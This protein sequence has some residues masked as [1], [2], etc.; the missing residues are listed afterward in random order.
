MTRIGI[1]GDVHSRHDELAI[2]LRLLDSLGC[3]LLLCVG[4][5][6]DGIGSVDECCHILME[7]SI[8][9]VR[10]NH[11]RW[12]FEGRMRRM[13][14]ATQLVDLNDQSKSFLNTLPPTRIFKIDSE[15]VMLCHGLGDDDMWRPPQLEEPLSLSDEIAANLRGVSMVFHG[16]THNRGIVRLPSSGTVLVNAGSLQEP[17][18]SVTVVDLSERIGEHVKVSSSESKTLERFS[19]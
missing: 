13:K 6:V 12:L 10:G 11:D 9:T 4:D 5:I 18:S 15:T 8:Q 17:N 16:H 2:A 3:D 7:R 19:F 1:I 14:N